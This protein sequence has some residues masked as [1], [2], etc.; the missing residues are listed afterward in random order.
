MVLRFDKIF[1]NFKKLIFAHKIFNTKKFSIQ[2]FFQ[3][4]QLLKIYRL[5]F[6]QQ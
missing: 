6:P 2:K 1:F 3:Y 5:A 4:K